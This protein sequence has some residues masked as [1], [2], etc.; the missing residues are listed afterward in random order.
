MYHAGLVEYWRREFN[1]GKVSICKDQKSTKPSKLRQLN[2]K[3]LGSA[4][5]ILAVGFT[6]SFFI[7]MM[8]Q[9]IGRKFHRRST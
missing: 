8:E 1:N 2:L 6:F 9:L 3:D 4:Y 7:F 5:F